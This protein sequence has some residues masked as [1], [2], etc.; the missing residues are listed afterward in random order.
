[1]AD[2][3]E[4][5]YRKRYEDTFAEYTKLKQRNADIE[6][7]I[8]ANELVERERYDAHIRQW[9]KEHPDDV[10]SWL[11]L[12]NAGGGG[13]Q[14]LGSGSSVDDLLAKYGD[15]IFDSES[16]AH[17][18]FVREQG[19]DGLKRIAVARLA[20]DVIRASGLDKRLDSTLSRIEQ[21]ETELENAKNMADHA[22]RYSEAS[23][24]ETQVMKNPRLGKV[25]KL[26]DEIKANPN[27]KWFEVIDALEKAQSSSA[28]ATATETRATPDEVATRIQDAQAVPA[29]AGA[30][31]GTSASQSLDPF[32]AAVA[33]AEA[34]LAG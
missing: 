19:V 32:D 11:E 29:G 3:K 6:K 2:E 17:Q 31:G 28:G 23:W 27:E 9:A 5:D 22:R 7:R 15:G 25:Q 16:E 26:M 18:K 13:Q 10:V 1:M 21:L 24:N 30:P 4:V 20:P 34:Q 14:A 33:A 8:E 12:K